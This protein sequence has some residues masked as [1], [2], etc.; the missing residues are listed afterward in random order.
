MNV[1][2][3]SA[4]VEAEGQVRVTGVPYEAGTQV[5]VMITP[6][7]NRPAP[8]VATSSDR[9]AGMFAALDKARN[10]EP[11]GRLVRAELYDRDIVH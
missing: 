7:A 10:T 6:L 3:T 9:S 5:E 1:F 8:S 11:V 4:T 2:E